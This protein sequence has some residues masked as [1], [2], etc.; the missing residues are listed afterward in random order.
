M[1]QGEVTEKTARRVDTEG[2][3]VAVSLEGGPAEV[4]ERRGGV[5]GVETGV[6]IRARGDAIGGVVGSGE[7]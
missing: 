5:G 2:A 4:D 1:A 7:A 6:K 3:R